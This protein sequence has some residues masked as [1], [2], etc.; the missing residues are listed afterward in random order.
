ML[1]LGGMLIYLLLLLRWVSDQ[2]EQFTSTFKDEQSGDDEKPAMEKRL[3]GFD[4]S[5]RYL[6][7]SNNL[8]RPP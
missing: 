8:G 1:Q 2:L 6:P 3:D 4:R 5:K 7:V